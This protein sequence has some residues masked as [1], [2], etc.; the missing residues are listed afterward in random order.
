MVT[1]HLHMHTIW[2]DMLLV[3]MLTVKRRALINRNGKLLVGM[4]W[5]NDTHLRIMM[6]VNAHFSSVKAAHRL[7]IVSS[8]RLSLGSLKLIDTDHLF[9]RILYVLLLGLLDLFRS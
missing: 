6:Q 4:W 7:H 1:H 3:R 8:N 9:G 5:A 2:V